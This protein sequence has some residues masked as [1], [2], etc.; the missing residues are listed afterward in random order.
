MDLFN[1]IEGNDGSEENEFTSLLKKNFPEE[2]AGAPPE[3]DE[4]GER[5]PEDADTFSEEYE[6]TGWGEEDFGEGPDGELFPDPESPKKKAR[7]PFWLGLVI[8][9]SVTLAAAALVFLVFLAPL[10]VKTAKSGTD[11]AYQTKISKL[12]AYLDQYALAEYDEELIETSLAKGLIAGLDDKYAQ[13]Y[14]AEEFAALI[15][16]ESGEYSGIGVSIIM[17]DDGNIEVYKVFSGTPASEA[18]I[19]V[20]D[21]ITEVE[22]IRDFETLDDIVALVRGATGTE[23]NIVIEHDGAEIPMTLVRAKVQEEAVQYRMLD[24]GIGYI[25][26]S[27]FVKV[28]DSQFDTAL[29]ELA[30]QGMTS[31][32]IDLRDNPGGDYDTVVSMGNRILP[33]GPIMTVMDKQGTIKTEN[34][35]GKHELKIPMVVLI[36]RNSASASEVFAGAIQDY[37]M[38]TIVGE[39]SYGKGVVQSLFPLYDGSGVK[40]T[41]MKYYTPSGDSVDGVGVIPDIEVS[42]PDDIWDDGVFEEEEDTQFLKG[43][44]ILTGKSEN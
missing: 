25:Y 20:G 43:V 26:I 2:E 31:L 9:A 32:M 13:Y 5:V 44:E 14:T 1:D 7:L 28:A 27:Q 42:L 10:T 15:E 37:G 33:E 17:N 40:F 11:S 35:D 36:N 19:V 30:G 38:A 18:G 8:G 4:Q 24:G 21:I 6:D 23:V 3:A 22:G 41:T 34:S 39:T 16:G 29:N 12:L